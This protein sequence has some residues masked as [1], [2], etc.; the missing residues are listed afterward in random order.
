M[1]VSQ[2]SSSVKFSKDQE[3]N[4]IWFVEKQKLNKIENLS[5]TYEVSCLKA[6]KFNL[7][8]ICQREISKNFFLSFLRISNF[9]QFES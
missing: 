5:R 1:T 3:M 6:F 9:R 7:S 8:K 2:K 4:K